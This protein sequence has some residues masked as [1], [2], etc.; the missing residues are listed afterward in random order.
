MIERRLILPAWPRV[1]SALGIRLA[2]AEETRR[3]RPRSKIAARL[4]E[5]TG[6]RARRQARG[7]EAYSDDQR[8]G[9]G[10]AGRQI[11]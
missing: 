4:A 9:G 8:A 11:K 5:R 3:H 2:H 1:S 10:I 6:L 7:Q